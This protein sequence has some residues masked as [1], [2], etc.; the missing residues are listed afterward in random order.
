MCALEAAC[1]GCVGVMH[2]YPNCNVVTGVASMVYSLC[3]Q[4]VSPTIQ[5][6]DSVPSGARYEL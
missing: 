5:S 4:Y 1:Y 6:R 3:R 2:N